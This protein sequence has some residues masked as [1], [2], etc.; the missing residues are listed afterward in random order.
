MLWAAGGPRNILWALPPGTTAQ[1]QLCRDEG[2][3]WD[4]SFGVVTNPKP[5][6]PH[7]PARLS[8]SAPRASSGQSIL[9]AS[10]AWV[11]KQKRARP[12]A[13]SRGVF[14][15]RTSTLSWGKREENAET[16]L[17][18]RSREQERVGD[19]HQAGDPVPPILSG[20]CSTHP[21]IKGRRGFATCPAPA[22]GPVHPR[23]PERDGYGISSRAG[24]AGQCPGKPR[25]PL[26]LLAAS[27]PLLFLSFPV[28]PCSSGLLHPWPPR[29]GNS[30]PVSK[31]AKNQT[32]RCL[33]IPGSGSSSRAVRFIP[34][35]GRKVSSMRL[36]R[37]IGNKTRASQSWM[38]GE[39][40]A[41]CPATLATAA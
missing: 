28:S 31:M 8:T 40:R 32:I 4:I 20:N 27:P 25:E 18:T 11:R 17:G 12:Q 15:L 34:A 38:W 6:Q 16:V 14:S 2:G 26:P 30:L 39:A 9:G 22:K 10:K 33:Q 35:R 13:S 3:I 19:W 41:S 24:G 7:S 37:K 5:S 29:G 23:H 1:K 21:V 36:P